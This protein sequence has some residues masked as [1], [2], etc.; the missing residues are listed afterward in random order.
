MML[1]FSRFDSSLIRI[2]GEASRTMR[3]GA[4]LWHS[5]M[6]R[7]VSSSVVWIILKQAFVNSV[8]SVFLGPSGA[9]LIVREASVVNNV[10]DLAV[11]SA[12][13]VRGGPS[14]T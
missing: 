5:K 10:V 11:L 8:Q 14:E 12:L 7:K 2:Y 1:R 3:K 13:L 4:T 9:Y 6:A